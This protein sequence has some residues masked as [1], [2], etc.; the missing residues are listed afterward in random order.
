MNIDMNP[1][2][3]IASEMQLNM[4]SILSDVQKCWQEIDDVVH[5]DD[6]VYVPQNSTLCNAV[7]SQYYNDVFAEHFRKSRTAELMQQSYNWPDAVRDI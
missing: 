4:T 1:K 3:V 6:K 5:Y 7:I 2:I